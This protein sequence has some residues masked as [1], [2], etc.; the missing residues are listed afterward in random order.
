MNDPHDSDGDGIDD[1][2][3]GNGVPDVQDGGPNYYLGTGADGCPENGTG[4]CGAGAPCGAMGG[5]SLWMMFAGFGG[6]RFRRR[7]NR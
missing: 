3:D 7:R 4:Q 2:F 5:M 6:M 1:D